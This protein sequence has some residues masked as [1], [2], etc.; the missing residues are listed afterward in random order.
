[1][2]P[3]T[4]LTKPPVLKRAES[5]SKRLTYASSER[6]L[7]VSDSE[8]LSYERVRAHSAGCGGVEG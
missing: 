7:T 1:M 3:A 8:S 6:P 2:S 5:H 4:S